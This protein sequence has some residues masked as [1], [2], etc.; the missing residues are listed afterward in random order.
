[1]EEQQTP[2]PEAG[3]DAVVPEGT[4]SE[5]TENTE[6]QVKDQP[7]EGE[8]GAKPEAS[9]EEISPS[10]ARRERRK[11]EMERLRQEKA[12]AEQEAQRFKARLDRIE[13]AAQQTQPPKE[14]DFQDYAEYQAA[15]AAHKSMQALDARQKREIEEEAQTHQKRLDS[16][17]EQE[18]R[19]AAENWAA[20]V[21]DAQTRYADFAEVAQNPHLPINDTMAQIISSSDMGAD[22]AYHL[23]K[24][25]KEAAQ[26]AQMNPLEAAVELGGMMARLSLPQP[27]TTSETPDPIEPVKPKASA[28]VKDPSKMTMAEYKAWRGL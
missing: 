17:K 24:H 1:M 11:A 14:E 23:G 19:E 26:I 2:A 10:K 7:A 25:P 4:E 22:L 9:E 20:Q 8:E 27:K 21:K 5:A 13:Q 28:G 3:D 15:L 12:E 18:Q 6:G 16:L